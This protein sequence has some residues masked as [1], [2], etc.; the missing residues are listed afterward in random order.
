MITVVEQCGDRFGVEPICRVFGY[1]SASMV[2]AR[3]NRQPS[4]RQV[5]DEQVL[6]AIGTVRVGNAAC[7]GARRTWIALRR[8][9]FEVARCTVER[10][11]RQHGLVGVTRGRKQPRTTTP[12]PAAVR[13]PDLVNRNFVAQRPDQLWLSDITYVPTLE[14]FVYVAFV[15]DAYSRRIIGWQTG[16][17]LRTDLPLDA[18][19]MALWN[20]NAG[21]G[22]TVRH[23]AIENHGQ[24]HALFFIGG[25]VANPLTVDDVV[26]VGGTGTADSA[27]FGV[28]KPPTTTAAVIRNS[29]AYEPSTAA[30]S[31]AILSELNLTVRNVTAVATAPGIVGLVQTGNCEPGTCSANATSTVINSIVAGGPGAA[32][33]RTTAS[34]PM[35]GCGGGPCFGNVSL[36]Y[37]NF[38]NLASCTGCSIRTIRIATGI[39]PPQW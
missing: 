5:R 6:Q 10:V 35:A 34:A 13:P 8:A 4:A 24:G 7:Y 39:L 15:M 36:D 11:M 19:E 37:S 21:D 17:H 26:A 23:L 32:D 9:G 33:M 31:A 12:D 25:T 28:A 3:R 27:M 16:D 22:K 2:Y 14:G 18:L 1:K 29:T 38:D 20:R 30:N